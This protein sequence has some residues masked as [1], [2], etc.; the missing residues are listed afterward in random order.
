MSWFDDSPGYAQKR[1]HNPELIAK[2]GLGSSLF[3]RRY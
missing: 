3:A 1:P 2:L